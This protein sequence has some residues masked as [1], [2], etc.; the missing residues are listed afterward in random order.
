MKRL[1]KLY[2]IILIF[3]FG[4]S[5]ELENAKHLAEKS[6]SAY[7]RSIAVY[8]RLLAKNNKNNDL[9][10]ELARLYLGHGDYDS[11]IAALKDSESQKSKMLL[12]VALYKSGD[13]TQA[14]GIFEKLG[15]IQDGEYLY[16]Y[17]LTCKK[18]N[19]Y[20]QALESLS[21][22]KDKAYAPKAQELIKS[23]Q[24][25]AREYLQNTIPARLIS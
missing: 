8:Q 3:L 9:R 4:C 25:S 2:C 11:A 22:I 14:L 10:L 12:A 19:L 23:I 16:Y 1:V 6:Q 20:E 17:A 5:A 7:R 24:G 13:Y 15:K 21:R 18:H